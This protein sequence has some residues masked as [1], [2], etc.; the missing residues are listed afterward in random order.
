MLKWLVYRH[1]T[2]VAAFG[3][4]GHAEQWVR[5]RDEMLSFKVVEA[6]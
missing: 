4:R 5:S 2:L 3:T 6:E 1:G